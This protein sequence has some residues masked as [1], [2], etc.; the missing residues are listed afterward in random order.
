MKWAARWGCSRS[1]AGARRELTTSMD[2]KVGLKPPSR[3]GPSRGSAAN[4][5][6][7]AP[8]SFRVRTWGPVPAPTTL[9]ISSLLT[10]LHICRS[11]PAHERASHRE[12]KTMAPKKNAR[13]PAPSA[14]ATTQSST[15]AAGSVPQQPKPATSLKSTGAANW[16]EVLQNIYQ[17]YMKETPQRTKLVDV[18]LVF[19]AA[20]GA[21]Q[22]LYCILAGNYVSLRESAWI[23]L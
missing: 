17:Y 20:V 21:L 15:T 7:P 13:E 22:F 12:L 19:L 4:H 8:W 11:K 10:T 23:E 3:P 2:S 5:A 14:A 1:W 18:F 6:L 16:D 9:V